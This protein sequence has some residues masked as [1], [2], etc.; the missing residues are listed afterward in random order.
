MRK[1]VVADL[2]LCELVQDTL[3][4]RP[5]V[6]EQV[7]LVSVFRHLSLLLQQLA[8]VGIVL[9]QSPGVALLCGLHGLGQVVLRSLLQLRLLLGLLYGS[10]LIAPRLVSL[11]CSN[12]LLQSLLLSEHLIALFIQIEE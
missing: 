6:Q 8:Q 1:V 2:L 9:G 10:R 4:S 5:P 11:G 12:L 7:L 3:A